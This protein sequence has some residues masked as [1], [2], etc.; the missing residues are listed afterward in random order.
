MVDYSKINSYKYVYS[1]SKYKFFSV[2]VSGTSIYA[3][4]GYLTSLIHR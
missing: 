1:A 2:E 4:K 3:L